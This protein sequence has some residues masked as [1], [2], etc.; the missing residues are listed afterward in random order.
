MS[1]SALALVGSAQFG[2]SVTLQYTA[3]NLPGRSHQEL[4]LS[5]FD[6]NGDQVFLDVHVVNPGT[7]LAD[8]FGPLPSEAADGTATAK[9]F[10]YTWKGQQETGLV[11]EQ[12]IS[13]P[14]VAG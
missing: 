12:S 4:S 10:Y 3:P 14:V 7:D 13:V 6:A 8:T 9:L 5:A 1:D 2:Q 11:V